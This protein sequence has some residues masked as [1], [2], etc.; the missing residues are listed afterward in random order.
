MLI[1]AVMPIMSV[2][3]LPLGQYGYSGHV[4]NLP[5]DVASFV[6]SLPRL[7]S[8]LDVIVVRKE[9]ANQT[10][11]DFRVRRGVVQRALQWLVSHNKYYH[12]LGVTIDTT[13]LA[14][15]PQDGNIS[16]L[17]SVI[18]DCSSPDSPTNS[19]T[20][21]SIPASD[22][23]HTVAIDDSHDHLPQSFVPIAVPSMTQQESVQQSVQQRQSNTSSQTPLMHHLRR[24][25]PTSATRCMGIFRTLMRT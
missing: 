2:Y 22:T 9:G 19:E 11:R 21:S 13:A 3:R 20:S 4:V 23:T 18:E 10:H 14:Q 8:D 7:P 25:T 16:H 6:Q 15:L 12:A 24:L 1:S 17:M 5:Q